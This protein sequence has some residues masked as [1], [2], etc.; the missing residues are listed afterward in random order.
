MKKQYLIVLFFAIF[1]IPVNSNPPDK[2]SALSELPG[3]KPGVT[4]IKLFNGRNLDGWYTYIKEKGKNTDPL[5]VFTVNNGMIRISGEEFGCITT[6]DEFENY[7]LTV[8]F[9]WGDQTYSPRTDKTRD[10]GILLH[11]VG[12]DG[13]SSGTW[14][15]SIEC[16]IIEGGTGDFIVV[17]DGSTKYSITSPVA[18]EKQGN[19]YIFKPE[20]SK[21][22]INSGRIN[23][24]GRDPEWKDV[25]DFRG[26][27]DIEKPVGKW[28]KI[29]CIVKGNE[30]HNYLNGVLVN[31]AFDVKPQKGKIQIQSEGAEIFFKKIII[32]PL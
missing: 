18:P 26:R 24:F 32:T 12:E 3:K 16:Q 15:Y 14:M 8:K 13:A 19:S 9:K 11:S 1:I 28:N 21:V 31:Q 22:T 5:N 29:E 17:G 27:N 23:W 25:K 4:S 7:K 2:N 10:S 6:N 20:G 30:I